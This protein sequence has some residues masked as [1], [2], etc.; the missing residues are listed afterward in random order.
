MTQY[1]YCAHALARLRQRGR[2]EQDVD[3]ILRYGTPVCGDGIV[4]LDDD[5]A[6][7]LS[8][9]R[10]LGER[11]QKLANWKVVLS[12]ENIIT[13]YRAEPRHQKRLL[14]DQRQKG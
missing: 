9:L 13:I 3:L 7:T 14:R 10:R 11:L 4:L 8:D 12:G 2:C 5:V 6:K 1:Q